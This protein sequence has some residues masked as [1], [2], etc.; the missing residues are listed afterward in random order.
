MSTKE[1]KTKKTPKEPII[2]KGIKLDSLDE[3]YMYWW[4]EEAQREGFVSFFA[5][6]PKPFVLFE[7]TIRTAY[8]YGKRVDFSVKGKYTLTSELTYQADFLIVFTQ[9]G[10]NYRIA[11]M[12][13]PTESFGKEYCFHPDEYQFL[14]HERNGMPFAF[15]DV[16][17]AIKGIGGHLAS[18]RDFG[19]KVPVIYAQTGVFVNETNVIN[20]KKTDDCLFSKTFAPKNYLMRPRVDGKGYYKN[21][22]QNKFI[23]DFLNEFSME[24]VSK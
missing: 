4:L 10:L 16:K 18:T 7:K 3:L 5:Y 1:P 11:G 9:K 19:I 13:E 24:A 12:V 20:R 14:C 6:H 23:H 15:N 17:P 21:Y 8:Q 2:Y 22:C